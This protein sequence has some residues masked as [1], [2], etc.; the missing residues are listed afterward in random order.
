MLSPSI[1]SVS[2]CGLAIPLLV[3]PI[4][5]SGPIVSKNVDGSGRFFVGIA[6]EPVTVGSGF[7]NV[8]S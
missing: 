6:V 1:A 5:G 7:E 2:I 4:V 3:G 8:T